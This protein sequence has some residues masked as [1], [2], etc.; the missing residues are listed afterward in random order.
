MS[1][2]DPAVFRII[3][4]GGYYRA[5]VQGGSAVEYYGVV[6]LAAAERAASHALGLPAIG[7]FHVDPRWGPSGYNIG[8]VQDVDCVQEFGPLGWVARVRFSV[9]G[10]FNFGVK[11]GSTSANFQEQVWI[12][13]LGD[14]QLVSSDPHSFFAVEPKLYLPRYGFTSVE[15]VKSTISPADIRQ[16]FLANVGKFYD[17]D[18]DQDPYQLIHVSI[19]TDAGNNTRVDT[20]FRQRGPFFGAPSGTYTGQDVDIPDLPA[21]CEWRAAVREGVV[22]VV[23]PRDRFGDGGFLPWLP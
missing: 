16:L 9:G 8:T 5:S 3:N 12:P 11:L 7:A 13:V 6:G 18:N 2:P 14:G 10:T 15:S 4:Y 1:T 21:N 17:R 20:M 22:E 19:T 23:N